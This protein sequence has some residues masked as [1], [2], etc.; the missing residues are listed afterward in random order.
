MGMSRAKKYAESFEETKEVRKRRDAL[1]KIIGIE[2][3]IKEVITETLWSGAFVGVPM[4]VI[5]LILVFTYKISFPYLALATLLT[6]ILYAYL[7]V[8][9]GIE[10][11]VHREIRRRMEEEKRD[12]LHRLS[13]GLDPDVQGP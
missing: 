13:Q 6:F 1:A 4:F 2:R 5:G 10:D 8:Q 7:N 9:N 3:L 11:A 12:P